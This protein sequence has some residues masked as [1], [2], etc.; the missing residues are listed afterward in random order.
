M[1]NYA[2]SRLNTVEMVTL[3]NN[4]VVMQGGG[5]IQCS[6]EAASV[7]GWIRSAGGADICPGCQLDNGITPL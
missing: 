5:W 4:E 6:R 7:I 2:A 1:V 3:P